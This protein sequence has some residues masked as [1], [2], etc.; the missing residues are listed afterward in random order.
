MKRVVCEHAAVYSVY[1]G[2]HFIETFDESLVLP[3]L[4]LGT[5]SSS[6]IPDGGRYSYHFTIKRRLVRDKEGSPI[7]R[8]RTW[9]AESPGQKFPYRLKPLS[10]GAR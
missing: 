6:E 5:F 3:K 8:V 9:F 7:M 4:I 1:N 2:D 10:H